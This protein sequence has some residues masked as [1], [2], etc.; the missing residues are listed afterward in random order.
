MQA[1]ELELVGMNTMAASA[2]AV[3]RK[4]CETPGK[5]PPLACGQSH[6]ASFACKSI[7]IPV[8]SFGA[9][10][11]SADC[12]HR[13]GHGAS[14]TSS[15]RVRHRRVAAGER[16]TAMSQTRPCV[17]CERTSSGTSSNRLGASDPFLLAL[18]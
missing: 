10:P 3:T 16:S 1:V 17:T 15:R 9:G 18:R 2:G 13:E 7:A 5:R 4:T 6:L 8:R 14:S 12:K 11:C